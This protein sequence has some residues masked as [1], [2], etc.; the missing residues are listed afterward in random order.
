[1]KTIEMID[2]EPL[3]TFKE[4]MHYLRVSR[5]TLWRLMSAQKVQGRKVGG[6]WRFTKEDLDLVSRPAAE[7]GEAE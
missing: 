2:L 5:S 3:Y 4:A 7:Q 1:M 6:T